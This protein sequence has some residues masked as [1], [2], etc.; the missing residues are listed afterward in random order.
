MVVR[1]TMNHLDFV[2]WM[3]LFPLV[4]QAE[5]L[6]AKK[7]GKIIDLDG[8]DAD[9]FISIAIWLGVGALLFFA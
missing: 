8:T 4:M 7:A 1:V 3:L 9:A 5:D 6:I 2:L